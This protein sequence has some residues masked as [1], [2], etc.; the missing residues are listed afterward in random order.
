MRGN[1]RRYA[2]PVDEGLPISYQV[3]EAGIPVYASGSDRVGTVV[4]VIS[5]PAEDIFHGIVLR[6]DAGERFVAADQIVSLHE[7]GVDLRI[8]ADE[9]DGLP[10][11][12][13]SSPVY[14]ER[15]P[16]TEPTRWQRLVDR[17]TVSGPKG[18]NWTKE[19]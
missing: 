18:R 3:L 4:H 14:R 2:Q 11:P 17:F 5:A 1:A 9:V 6:T 7:H 10:Q 15:E 13:S 16:G 12:H 19:D 8:G